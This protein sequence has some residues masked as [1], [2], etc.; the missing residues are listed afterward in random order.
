MLGNNG[1]RTACTVVLFETLA[2]P[3]VAA[4]PSIS[5]TQ[6]LSVKPKELD[7]TSVDELVPVE[8]IALRVATCPEYAEWSG[9]T[10]SI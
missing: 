7:T 2:P 8:T 10:Q 6:S 4:H 5:M 9:T 1:S 3:N